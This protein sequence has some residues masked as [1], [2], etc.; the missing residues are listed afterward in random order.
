MLLLAIISIVTLDGK[1]K[2]N[3]VIYISPIKLDKKGNNETYFV[4]K[5]L[6]SGEEIGRVLIEGDGGHMGSLGNLLGDGYK[7]SS[8]KLGRYLRKQN[9]IND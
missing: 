4:L 9:P 8:R 1:L 6:S 3:Y 2:A 7:S 5:E